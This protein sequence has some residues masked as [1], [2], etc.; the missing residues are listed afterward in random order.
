MFIRAGEVAEVGIRTPGLLIANEKQGV[1][2]VCD[3]PRQTEEKQRQCIDF[4]TVRLFGERDGL[5]HTEA[6][7][8]TEDTHGG[9]TQGTI[10]A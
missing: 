3:R 2:T 7:L 6:G 1:A 8:E 10:W 4:E 9:Y 5:R